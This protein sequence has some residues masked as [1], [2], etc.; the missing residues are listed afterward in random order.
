MRIVVTGATGNLGTALLATAVLDWRVTGVARR[1]PDT[2]ALPYAGV[3]WIS[4]DIG[5]TAAETV[6]P[7][8]F[9]GADAVIHLGWAVHPHRNDPPMQRTNLGGS[10]NV[11]RAVAQAR[12]PHLVCASSAAVYTPAR[13]WEMVDETYPRHGVPGSAYSLQKVELERRLDVFE[14][15]HPT[16]LVSRIRPCGI[17]QGAAG[18][19]VADWILGAVLPRAAI[20][21]RW[22]PVPLW[23]GLRLQLVHSFDVAAAIRLIVRERAAGAFNLAADPVLPARALARQFGGF[24]LPVPLR[25]LSLAAWSGW[26]S[27]LHPLHPSWLGLA[28]RACLL[29]TARARRELGWS[30]SHDAETVCAELAAGLRRASPGHSAPLA[31]QQ[32]KIRPGS[33]THQSQEP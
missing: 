7:E 15:E 11:L 29:E 27:G 32:P 12:V 26:R 1:K 6:L 28:D 31:P 21:R 4:C 13:R 2:R 18:A 20:G 22:T 16:T 8:A 3:E 14:A 23:P 17:A 9:A 25:W 33:P 30:P 24:R 10:S 5:D 19:E